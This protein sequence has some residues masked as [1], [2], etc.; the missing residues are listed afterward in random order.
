MMPTSYNWR[1]QKTLMP[2]IVMQSSGQRR[3][4]SAQRTTLHWT[5]LGWRRGAHTCQHSTPNYS[6]INL[7]L[8]LSGLLRQFLNTSNMLYFHLW[9]L[10]V[11]DW[12]H[13]EIK[14]YSVFWYFMFPPL[15]WRICCWGSFLNSEFLPLG[16]SHLA[17][18]CVLFFSQ[19]PSTTE[20]SQSTPTRLDCSPG[21]P[22][23][24]RK[25]FSTCN[26]LNDN[27]QLSKWC[28]SHNK[29]MLYRICWQTHMSHLLFC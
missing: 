23:A 3:L 18:T 28:K 4:R 13:P 19:K 7:H 8:F 22:A 20:V 26:F 2:H 6:R 12:L 29:V 17:W 21:G 1:H 15:K 5:V 14:D 27:L 11:S 16:I 9:F 10:K 24:Q 25:A